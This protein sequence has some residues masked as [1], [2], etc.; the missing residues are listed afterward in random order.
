M[1]C[2][3]GLHKAFR[4]GET[5]QRVLCGV[6][7]DVAAGETLAV[8][9]VSGSG[10][11]TLLGILG[12]IVEPDAGSVSVA[13]REL[14]RLTEDERLAFRRDTVGMVFQEHRLLPQLTAEENVLLP[15]LADATSVTAWRPRA[16]ELLERIGMAHK[17]HAFP[18][19]LSG[20]ERQ[21]IAVARALL[22][23]PKVLLADE[24]T[25]ALDADTA[26]EVVALLA[27]L[28]RD[29]ATAIVMVTHSEAAA[30]AMRRTHTLRHGILR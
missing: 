9:G 11:S 8:T 1:I 13:G 7:M 20:G 3:R 2:V 5:T 14:S 24:P 22:R 30:N 16:M 15:S 4:V 10:K 27:S 28:A 23:S 12:A 21:R 25:G 18:H 19:E 17:R 26:A 6:D 29:T